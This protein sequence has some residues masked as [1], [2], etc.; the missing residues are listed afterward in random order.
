MFTAGV[1]TL[2]LSGTPTVTGTFSFTATATDCVGATASHTY[3]VTIDPAV[4]LTVLSLPASTQGVAYYETIGVSGGISTNK[5][6]VVTPLSGSLPLGMKLTTTNNLLSVTGTPT[7]SGTYTFQLK[8]TDAGGNSATSDYTLVINQPVTL[9]PASIPAGTAGVF[10]DQTITATG[11][12]GYLGTTYKISSG[13]VPTGLVITNANGAIT[14]IGTPATKGSFTLKVT[15][16]DSVGAQ[17]AQTYTVT[18]N[19]PVTFALSSLAH[20]SIGTNY[21]QTITAVG[22]TGTKTLTYDVLSGSIPPGLTITPAPNELKITGR[23]TAHGTITIKV[24]ATD[25][26]GDEAWEIL[27]LTV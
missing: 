10:Y 21:S 7:K 17:V 16:F 18:I 23:P 2:T 26:V 9:T 5:T 24:I 11:G 27:T 19:T 13:S 14:V 3:T 25:A 8:A 15:A 22:G 1:N 12:T 20:A 4:T 6:P